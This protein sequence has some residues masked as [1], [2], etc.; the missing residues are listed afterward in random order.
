MLAT[1]GVLPERVQ[2]AEPCPHPEGQRKYLPGTMGSPRRFE[3]GACNETVTE[4]APA[5]AGA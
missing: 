3:C 4:T 1:L 2:T 5:G